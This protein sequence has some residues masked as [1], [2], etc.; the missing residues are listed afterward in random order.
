MTGQYNPDTS[1]ENID[2]SQR[3]E[4]L[5][6]NAESNICHKVDVKISMKAWK[7]HTKDMGEKD[8]L[9]LTQTIFSL[10]IC[11]HLLIDNTQP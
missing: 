7:C 9:T 10:Q 6:N 4:F 3:I 8:E 1:E 11:T 5:T 2:A